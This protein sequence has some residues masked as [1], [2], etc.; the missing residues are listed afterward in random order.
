MP[1]TA[2]YGLEGLTATTFVIRTEGNIPHIFARNRS[3][4]VLAHGFTIASEAALCSICR[5]VYLWH[6]VGN[7]R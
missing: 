7:S 3:D 6:R 1:E 5:G 4:L 2:A